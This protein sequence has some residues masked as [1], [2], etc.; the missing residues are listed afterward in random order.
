M[1]RDCWLRSLQENVNLSKG[2]DASKI[3]WRRSAFHDALLMS[4]TR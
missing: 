1:S 2:K 3:R 4:P